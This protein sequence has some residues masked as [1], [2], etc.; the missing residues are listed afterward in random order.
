LSAFQ[1]E[2]ALMHR[3]ATESDLFF[4]TEGAV[5]IFVNVTCNDGTPGCTVG[6][7]RERPQH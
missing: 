7:P 2:Q 4:I 5:Q 3:Y 1:R 6:I